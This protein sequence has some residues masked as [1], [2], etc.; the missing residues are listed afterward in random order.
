MS[1]LNPQA[2]Y[3]IFFFIFIAVPN[4]ENG[5]DDN[6]NSQ[7]VEEAQ[8]EAANGS[9]LTVIGWG[10]GGVR[11]V[12]RLGCQEHLHIEWRIQQ[13]VSC[14]DWISLYNSGK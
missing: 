11:G 7:D 2:L 13:Q 10:N 9:R 14:Q 3:I 1:L 6:G 8:E 12:L 4:E 5:L